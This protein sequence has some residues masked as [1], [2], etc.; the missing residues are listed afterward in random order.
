MAHLTWG[1]A[2]WS[3][4]DLFPGERVRQRSPPKPWCVLFGAPLCGL[5]PIC[6]RARG[7]A[8]G[9]LRSH[10]ASYSGLLSVVSPRSVSGREGALRSY[11]LLFSAHSRS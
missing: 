11:L 3:L 9:A 5:S 6:F 7:C 8:R 1:P 10:G 2:L 4:P